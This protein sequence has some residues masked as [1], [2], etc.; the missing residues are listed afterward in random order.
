MI[1]FFGAAGPLIALAA[2]AAPA[3]HASNCAPGWP[4][5]APAEHTLHRAVTPEDLMALRDIGN[6]MDLPAEPMF[7]VSPDNNFAALQLRRADPIANTYCLAMVVVD[8]RGKAP[9]IV[10]DQGGEALKWR[11]A[12]LLGKADFPNGIPHVSTP[13]WSSDGRAIY[14]LKKVG[15][16]AQIWRARRDGGGSVPVTA[17][18]VDVARFIVRA[19]GTLVFATKTGAAAATA[20]LDEEG[21]SG[22]RYDERYLPAASAL[23]FPPAPLP[24]SYFASEPGTAKPRPATKVEQDLL[25]PPEGGADNRP[26]GIW[27]KPI[28]ASRFPAMTTLAART[29]AGRA[30]TCLHAQCRDPYPIAWWT[31]DRRSI[32]YMRREGWGREATAFYRWTPSSNRLKRLLV[33]TD[34]FLSCQL[35]DSRLICAHEAATQPRRLAAIDTHTGKLTSLYD[36]NQDFRGL[37]LGKVER[38]RWR[39]DGVEV[40]SDLV[41]PVNYRPGLRYPLVVV[42]Y[43]SIGFLRG[44]VGDDYPV[45]AFASRDYFVLSFHRPDRPKAAQGARSVVELERAA[46]KNFEGRRT[47]LKA[48]EAGVQTVITRGLIDPERVGLSGLSEGSSTVQFAGLNSGMFKAAAMSSCCWEPS[49]DAMLGP[50]ISKL[51]HDAGYPRLVDE[52]AGFWS[53][54]SWQRNANRVAF[55]VLMQLSDREYL[56]G[57]GSFTAL[58]QAGRPAALYIFP[59][60][61]HIK[62]HPAHRL[63]SYRR[64]LAWFEFWLRPDQPTKAVDRLFVRDWADLRVKR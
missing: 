26:G 23:P 53:Q 16:T 62:F 38:L 14:F 25:M 36:P 22:F 27:L 41:Y 1:G 37:R 48:L 10:V 64:S 57:V 12:N 9:P 31:T 3:Q 52:D 32:L 35:A 13:I 42:Q 39:T 17:G 55:P 2:S 46:L 56:N 33:S 5:A 40:F 21:R 60:E 51:Y 19:G 4:S 45:Q 18:S 8:L 29:R 63:A 20:A 15:A 49:Q 6:E 30:R 7:A 43:W 28:D 50:N 11:H 24:P 34:R 54:L 47:N 58:R 61:D 44:G 59:D